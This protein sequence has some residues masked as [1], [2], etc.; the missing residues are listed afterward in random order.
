MSTSTIHRLPNADA[1]AIAQRVRALRAALPFGVA[2]LRP[3]LAAAAACSSGVERL[4]LQAVQE[5]ARQL[6]ADND[7]RIERRVFG[8]AIGIGG[9]HGRSIATRVLREVDSGRA[10]ARR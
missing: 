10:L 2:D 8:F 1:P 6:V 3:R 7:P 9:K 5:L 4:R